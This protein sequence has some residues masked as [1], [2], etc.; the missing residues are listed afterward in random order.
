M[1][2]VAVDSAGDLVLG[3]ALRDLPSPVGAVAA[4]GRL[5]VLPGEQR[6]RRHRLGRRASSCAPD[7]RSSASASFTS[8]GTRRSWACGSS[9]PAT[10]SG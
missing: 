6:L 10:G 9:R 5:D 3:Q 1:P 4:L 8:A 7:A 2:C